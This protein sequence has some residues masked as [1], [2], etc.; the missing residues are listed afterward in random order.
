MITKLGDFKVWRAEALIKLY[1]SRSQKVAID[2]LA[3]HQS[4]DYLITMNIN[5]TPYLF[6]VIL[7]T[8]GNIKNL[9]LLNSRLN[10]PHSSFTLLMFIVADINND[11]LYYTWIKNSALKNKTLVRTADLKNLSKT[12]LQEVFD[13]VKANA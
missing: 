6:P 11:Q 4:I 8:T 13:F 12:G 2:K 10:I 3:D 1:F 5:N 7:K 9:K